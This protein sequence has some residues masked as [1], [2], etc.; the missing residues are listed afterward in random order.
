MNKINNI[1]ICDFANEPTKDH[2]CLEAIWS[3]GRYCKKCEATC[4]RKG[5]SK[6]QTDV[7]NKRLVKIKQGE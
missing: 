7:D 3:L 6:K 5:W 4:Y 2:E 1:H